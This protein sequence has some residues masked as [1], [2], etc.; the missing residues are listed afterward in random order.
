MGPCC[1]ALFHWDLKQATLG[2]GLCPGTDGCQVL[3]T[4]TRVWKPVRPSPHL[5]TACERWMPSEAWPSCAGFL[6]P[7]H[8]ALMSG[9]V[10]S[11]LVC[12]ITW[13]AETESHTSGLTNSRCFYPTGGGCPRPP[14]DRVAGGQLPAVSSPGAGRKGVLR[15]P[16]YKDS[17]PGAPA[18]MQG[19]KNPMQ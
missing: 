10:L 9:H 16:L 1:T 15:G 12:A 13:S 2:T 17:N 14:A 11:H 19:V 4:A 8:W 18:A 5:G 6:A 3:P 7:R